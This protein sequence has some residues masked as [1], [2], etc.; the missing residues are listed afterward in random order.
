MKNVKIQ[1]EPEISMKGNLRL[2]LLSALK[3]LLM[4]FQTTKVTN[5]QH[6]IVIIYHPSTNHHPTTKVTNHKNDKKVICIVS[7]A[8]VNILRLYF[9]GSSLAVVKGILGSREDTRQDYLTTIKLPYLLCPF[10]YFVSLPFVSFFAFVFL[11]D[12]T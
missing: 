12:M 2:Q 11:E 7:L 1:I 6:L 9:V 10:H 5:P 3:A 8:S 4:S